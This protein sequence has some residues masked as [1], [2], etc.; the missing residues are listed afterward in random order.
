MPLLDVSDRDGRQRSVS[1]RPEA[2]G[3]SRLVKHWLAG[4]VLR[5]AI[6]VRSVD[7]MWATVC[8]QELRM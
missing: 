1:T 5:R 3:G 4:G 2:S 7:P 6:E 8:V